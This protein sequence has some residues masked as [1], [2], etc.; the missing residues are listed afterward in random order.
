MFS[1]ENK[2]S[3]L[4]KLLNSF[5]FVIMDTCS[6]MEDGFPPF[7]DILVNA[8]DYLKENARITV[9]H[10][11]LEELKKHSKNK[12]SDD[13]RIAAKRAIKILKQ[14]KRAKLFDFPKKEKDQNFADNVIYVSVSQMRITKKVL[15]I[16]QD[17][18]LA[19]DLG[20]LN[21]LDS[22]KGRKVSTY[23]LLANGILDVNRG[24]KGRYSGNHQRQEQRADGAQAQTAKPVK[25]DNIN[26]LMAKAKSH[27]DNLWSMLHNPNCPS[28]R[29]KAD[30]SAQ[31]SL[32]A[33]IPEEN[34]KTMNLH[35]LQPQLLEELRK[36]DAPTEAKPAPK[37]PEQEPVKNAAPAK[38]EEAKPA[39]VPQIRG[40]YGNGS[41]L[42]AAII[43]AARYQGILFRDES[44]EYMPQ[45]HGGMNLT[46]QELPAIVKTVREGPAEGI[47][48][49]ERLFIRPEKAIKGIR[50]S[51]ALL[52]EQPVV[53]PELAKEEKPAEEPKPKKAPAKKKKPAPKAEEPAAKESGSVQGTLIV[54]V[55]EEKAKV[56]IERKVKKTEPVAPKAKKEKAAENQEPKKK[57]PKKEAV[58]EKPEKQTKKAA[59]AKKSTQ[60]SE[61][62]KPETPKKK[63]TEKKPEAAKKTSAKQP[64]LK[65]PEQKKPEPKA[66][67]AKQKPAE[68]KN[69]AQPT[70]LEKAQK[71]EARLLSVLSNGN[72]PK[73]SKL[74]DIKAQLELVRAL[75][76]EEVAKLK[77]NADALKGMIGLMS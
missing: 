65:Q 74:A 70:P 60:K 11:C 58:S 66:S 23:R 31:L 53:K 56:A 1:D 21:F 55:P 59:S 30:I 75:K 38:K 71:A 13:T 64:E 67:K 36:A 52:K 15:V 72:Y 14:A 6:L 69:P 47:T 8:K 33:K 3:S 27:D 29:K 44:V 24:E 46:A 48:Y 41:T 42:E 77:Y 34:R 7:M 32:L 10:S 35:Y 39:E 57:A 62:S 54:A 37:K 51:L 22:Q 16:T 25:K 73:E 50:V 45:I 9:Y 76:P 19:E 20:R 26:I 4:A 40:F 28:K 68:N 49:R 18:G 63:A 5:D 61:E 43:D 17:K 12:K 2:S